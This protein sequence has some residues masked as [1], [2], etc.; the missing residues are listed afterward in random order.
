M[1][2]KKFT[3]TCNNNIFLLFLGIVLSISFAIYAILNIS[4]DINS[5]TKYYEDSNRVLTS[6]YK[7]D[8][9][10]II[11]YIKGNSDEL[12]GEYS[13]L[14]RDHMVDVRG[15]FRVGNYIRMIGVFLFLIFL[16]NLLRNKII[17]SQKN[18]LFLIVGLLLI[19]LVIFIFVQLDFS[20][21]FVYFHK[22]PF[23]NDKWLLPES[24]RLIQILPE[25][26]FF[27]LAKKII[28]NYLIFA[29]GSIFIIYVINIINIRRK[30][31]KFRKIF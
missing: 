6:E 19:L 31:E 8:L 7:S 10:N 23:T 30:N 26:L 27:F 12:I 11:E 16:Y 9:L 2:F 29:I 3:T 28:S 18:I 14:E 20:R 13:Q 4:F 15:L 17:L 25:D 5:Y 1:I 21:F 24:S 22:L